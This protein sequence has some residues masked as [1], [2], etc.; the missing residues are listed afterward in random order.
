MRLIIAG[1]RTFND[2]SFLKEK[3]LDFIEEIIQDI[4]IT[5]IDCF[6]DWELIEGECEGTD[7]LGKRFGWEAGMTIREYPAD[8]NRLGKKAGPIRN[9]QMA[10]YASQSKRGACIVFDGGGPGS[11]NMIKQAKEY[12][13]ILKIIKI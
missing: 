7:L 3:V 9:G 4:S 10:E 12:G 8:W 11:A 1:S 13:L 5:D 6:K 2:F